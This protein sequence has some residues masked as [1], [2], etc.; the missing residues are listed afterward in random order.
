MKLY[1]SSSICAEGEDEFGDTFQAAADGKGSLG[2][3][4]LT[5]SFSHRKQNPSAKFRVIPLDEPVESRREKG[6]A[7]CYSS[8][9]PLKLHDDN[10]RGQRLISSALY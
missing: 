4:R 3:H 7:S 9:P 6:F 8:F 2:K 5:D 10:W 1:L